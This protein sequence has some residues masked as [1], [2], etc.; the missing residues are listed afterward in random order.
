M[1][2]A[3]STSRNK[4]TGTS[5]DE[6]E[7]CCLGPWRKCSQFASFPGPNPTCS[8]R[9]TLGEIS[10]SGRGQCWL[11]SPDPWELFLP[12]SSCRP[13]LSMCAV[14][15]LS[16]FSRVRL[17]NP[18]DCSPPGSSLHGFLQAK[19]LE[20]VAVHSS[21]GSPSFFEFLKWNLLFLS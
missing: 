19:I 12:L 4:A 2:S 5:L 17:C 8:M 14:C 10:T 18:V 21:R 16:H 15:M 3:G 6:W 7:P 1:G 13:P 9:R 11:L 20:W